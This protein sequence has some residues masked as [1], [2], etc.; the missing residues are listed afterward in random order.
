VSC[1]LVLG[2][3]M[4]KKHIL[5]TIGIAVAV[6]AAYEYYK[7]HGSAGGSSPFKVAR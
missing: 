5:P 7:S 4:P 2:A 6:V 3:I 1:A